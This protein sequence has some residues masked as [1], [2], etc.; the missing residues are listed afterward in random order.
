MKSFKFFDFSNSGE[1]DYPTFQRAIAKMGVAVDESDLQQFF[2][3]YDS[4]GN[5]KLDYKEFSDI[6]FGKSQASGQTASQGGS[7]PR[8][9]GLKE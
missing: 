1:V 6:V 2:Q 3:M 5:G 8:F 9:R 7:N 4:N